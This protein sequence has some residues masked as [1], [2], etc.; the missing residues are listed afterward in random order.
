MILF[1]LINEIIIFSLRMR[2]VKL[3]N[4]EFIEL[5]KRKGYSGNVVERKRGRCLLLSHKQYSIIE[6]VKIL[7]MSRSTIIRLF[8]AWS[9]YQ[10][11]SLRIKSGR[12]AKINCLIWKKL[13]DNS[14][15]S[16]IL[17]KY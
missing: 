4:N 15:K 2:Y 13:L 5:T 14:S 6:I 11:D 3:S 9:K 17:I 10:Y 1:L 16:I 7:G 8:N 12:S